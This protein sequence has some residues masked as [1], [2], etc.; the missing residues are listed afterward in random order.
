MKNTLECCRLNTAILIGAASALLALGVGPALASAADSLHAPGHL[1]CEELETPLGI[2]TPQPHFSWQLVDSRTGAKQ[3]AWQIQVASTSEGLIAGRADVWD[4]GRIDSDRSVAVAYAGPPLQPERRYF[5]RVKV[6]D[7]EGAAYPASD[8]TW[9][10]TGLMREAWRAKW[11][12]SEDQELQSV[13]ESGAEWISNRGEEKYDHPGDTRHDFRLAFHVEKPVQ[14]AH[15]YVTGEDTAAAWINGQSVL[16]AE[17]LPPYKQT[18]WKKYVERDVTSE[19]REGNNLLAVEV[20][21]FDIGQAAQ[22]ANNSRTPMSACLYLKFHDGSQ[23]VVISNSAWK[24]DLNASG[25]WYAPQFDDAAWPSAVSGHSDVQFAGPLNARPWPTGPVQMLRH[26]FTVEKRV[27]SARLYATALGSYRLWIDGQPIGDQILA[28]GWTDYRERVP[29]QTYDATKEV[30][31]GSNVI[32]AY[33]APGWYTTPLEW[34]QEPYN[35]GNTPP[36]LRTELRIEYDDNSVDWIDS[37]AQWKASSSPIEKAE[38]YDGETYDARRE[39]PG[40]ATPE[41]SDAGWRPVEI[42]RPL[43]PAIVAQEYQ[44]IRIETTLH[45]KSLSEPEFGVFVFD[46]GQNMAG[47]AHIRVQGKPGTKLRVRFAEV[48]NPDGTIYTE[49]LRTALAT[50][51]FTLAGKGVEDYQ[52]SFT[53][54][55]FR[56]VELTGL[57]GKPDI[58][59]VTAKVIHTD[60]PFHAHLQTA[61]AILNQLWSNI[62]WGQRSNFV[63]V[64]TD[65]PQR[66]ERLGWSGDAEVF[67]RTASYNMGLA[68]FSRKFAADLRGTQV[69]TPMYGIYAPGTSVP[70]AG[71]GAGWSDA[72]VIIPWTSWVQSGDTRIVDQNWDAMTTYLGAIERSNPGFLWDHD[73]G[74]PFGDWLSPEGQTKAVLVQTAYWAYDVSLMKQMAHATGRSADEVKYAALLK[75]IQGAF[76]AA[77]VRDDG[78]IAGADNGPSP[79]GRIFV[80]N[81]VPSGDTQ[82]GY[83]LALYMHLVPDSLRAAAADRLVQK[84]KASGWRLG[85]GFLGT[86]Y[87]L[88]VLADT[89]HADVA[90]RLLLS[91]EY[92]SWG[93]LVTHGATTMWERWN[94]DQMR[95]DPSMNSYN[96]YAYGAVADWIYRYAAGIDAL[97]ADAGFHTIHLHPNFDAGL[98]SLQF[99]YDS[100]Y[101]EIRSAWSVQGSTATWNLTIPPN[102]RGEL[103]L[104]GDEENRFTL[105]GVALSHSQQIHAAAGEGSEATYEIPPGHYEFSVALV[106]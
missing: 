55:G 79:F 102:S 103:S 73:A 40:W 61:S 60:A 15:L 82:T 105:K 11:I 25:A 44:P 83:V 91:T 98:G 32:G 71:F 88:A 8:V 30:R 76:A 92:P 65:C 26:T 19:V 99:T 81:K 29:Y 37:D 39:Q 14:V 4:S 5:W 33:L 101:G 78:F 28:P 3:T 57:A 21:L 41:F 80:P 56:Y 10:E 64:P 23:Q 9:W 48:L 96:H 49:N 70:N 94:G 100:P 63:G 7:K 87:L 12:G 67:W 20:T 58:S 95:G 74:T 1:R 6:W 93:Y 16:S 106:R 59:A 50:D 43:E 27:R 85:T 90:Y 13:R 52:P 53:F 75:K 62:L 17:P 38:I 18:A 86:P 66:D 68:P 42:V 22:G 97:P 47:F 31:T 89:G 45:A 34:T 2:D 77:F 69:G 72:G 84:L 35:Y 46:F 54:H 24:A 51:Y 104:A 36:A